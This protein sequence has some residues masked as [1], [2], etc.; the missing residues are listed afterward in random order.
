MLAYYYVDRIDDVMKQVDVRGG[1]VV[2]PPYAEGNLWLAQV[3]DPAGDFGL[4][5]EALSCRN[6]VGFWRTRHRLEPLE[7]FKAMLKSP[8]RQA[9]F[10]VSRVEHRDRWQGALRRGRPPTSKWDE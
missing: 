8:E 9:A 2:K 7:T 5:E 6:C 10:A 1:E 4:W 3:R